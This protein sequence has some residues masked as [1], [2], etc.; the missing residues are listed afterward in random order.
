MNLVILTGKIKFVEDRGKYATF[1][2]STRDGWGENKKWNNHRCVAFGSAYN[3]TKYLA[4]GD[5]VEITGRI[6]YSEKDGKNYTN[7][8]IQDIKGVKTEKREESNPYTPDVE[9]VDDLPF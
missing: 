3:Y 8:I 5:Y 2:L 4:D 7:I 6:E 1:Q 9:P